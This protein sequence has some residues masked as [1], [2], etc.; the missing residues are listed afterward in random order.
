MSILSPLFGYF[1]LMLCMI[2]DKVYLRHHDFVA[3]SGGNDFIVA[4]PAE[5]VFRLTNQ[6]PGHNLTGFGIFP[7][8]HLRS[9]Y[10]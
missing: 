4:P 1:M 2:L 3:M 6:R 9:L 8:V 10:F 5:F 7:G